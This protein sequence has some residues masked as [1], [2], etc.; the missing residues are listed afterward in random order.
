MFKVSVIES[1]AQRRLLLEGSLAAPAVPELRTALKTAQADLGTHELVV[2]LK[3]VTSI[4]EEGVNAIL[5]VMN[6]G[7]TIAWVIQ[8]SVR[9]R[10]ESIG[11]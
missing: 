4:S 11:T 7:A 10:H 9:V 5:D 2:D 3:N 8:R 1:N 6:Q